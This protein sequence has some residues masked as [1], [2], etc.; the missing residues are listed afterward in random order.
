MSWGL[1][2]FAQSTP[3]VP[4]VATLTSNPA[5]LKRLCSAHRL[6]SLSSTHS[7]LVIAASP[8][9]TA[10]RACRMLH[11]NA[12]LRAAIHRVSSCVDE[13]KDSPEADRTEDSDG[14]SSHMP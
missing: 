14:F 5:R 1:S 13:D 3:S 12:P 4:F 8:Y 7:I 9:R 2:V 10:L 11:T 6:S